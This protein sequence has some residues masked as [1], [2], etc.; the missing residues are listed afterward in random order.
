MVSEEGQGKL[1]PCS[2]TNQRCRVPVL[3][4]V[5]GKQR[6]EIEMRWSWGTY[7]EVRLLCTKYIFCLSA[8][9]PQDCG[10]ILL[11][12]VGFLVTILRF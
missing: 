2:Y 8:N 11:H 6:D 3:S 9:S 10:A 1:H 12:L 7:T 4:W 5:L